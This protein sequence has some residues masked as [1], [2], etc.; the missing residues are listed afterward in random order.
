MRK[1]PRLY[2][3]F[4][5]PFSW[6]ALRRL[7]ELYPEAVDQ[8]EYR[9]FWEPDEDLLGRLRAGGGEFLYTPM[10]KAKH[11]YILYDTKRL[12][13]SFGYTMS[14][15]VD[16]DPWWEVPHL[17]WLHARREGRAREFY[18]AV[19]EAR[20]ERGENVCDP[21]VVR[22]LAASVGLD[23]ATA[24]AAA[25][26][27]DLREEGL[28]ALHDLYQD[29]VFGVPYFRV[30]RHRFWGLD[31][32]EAFTDALGLE[33]AEEEARPSLARVPVGADGSPASPLPGLDTDT[34]GGCG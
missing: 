33:R 3:A 34:A 14:W 19:T 1:P 28:R 16:V 6:M 23:G 30:G 15:P 17:A 20:W 9:P 2:F 25:S 27:P 32:L 29:D 24:A 7:E 10:S 13:A 12:A 5:S 26:D 11:L 31:R 18:R 22:D 8:V 21:A 4:R